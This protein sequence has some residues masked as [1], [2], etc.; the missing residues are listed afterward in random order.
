[1]VTPLAERM[2][3]AEIFAPPHFCSRNNRCRGSI[4]RSICNGGHSG[5]RLRRRGALCHHGSHL[6]FSAFLLVG[7]SGK[8]ISS[9]GRSNGKRCAERSE[10]RRVG[11]ECS[12]R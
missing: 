9:R 1:M 2:Y 8:R 5:W 11:K 3:E 12:S 4:F 7:A 10:E 6:L